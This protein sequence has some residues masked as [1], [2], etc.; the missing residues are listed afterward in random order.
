MR[1]VI[2]INPRAGRRGGGAEGGRRRAL[3]ARAAA[4]AGCHADVA[5][6]ERP[7]HAAD[8]ALAAVRSGVDRV[9]AWGG[10][11]TVNEAS[12]AV[13]GT[14]TALALVPSGS[15]NGLAR[16]LGIPRDELQALG[17]ALDPNRPASWIDAGRL[18]ARHF[19]NIGGVGFDAAVARAFNA[20]ARRGLWGYVVEG[21]R[22]VWAFEPPT[23]QVALDAD[24]PGPAGLPGPAPRFLV[25][26]ANGRQYGN[27][28]VLAPDA[29]PADGRLQA[30]VVAGGSALT[31]LWRARRLAVRRLAPA[32]GI[33]RAAVRHAE[34]SGERIAC[35]VDGETFEATGSIAVTIWPRALRVVRTA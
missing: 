10:D 35:Q 11:G 13:L 31:Q 32:R 14:A 30:V 7:G 22:T 5:L 26:F 6:T 33:V 24:A 29:D 25:A 21:L 27:G 18:G 1:V 15:G 8:L 12:G 28:L 3:A 17:V 23:L 34:I 20:R 9:V 16:A 19:L 4:A 2:I